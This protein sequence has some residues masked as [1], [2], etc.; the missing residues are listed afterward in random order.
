MAREEGTAGRAEVKRKYVFR[1]VRVC[2]VGSRVAEICKI[3][4]FLSSV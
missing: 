3:L 4:P 2:A 1:N